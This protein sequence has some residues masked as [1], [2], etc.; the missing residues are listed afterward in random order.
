[1]I[2]IASVIT[3]S[4][5]SSARAF[6]LSL[7]KTQKKFQLFTL[8]V[9]GLRKEDSWINGFPELNALFPEDLQYPPYEEMTTYYDA[10]ELCN[11]MRPV[12][13]SYLLKVRKLP[14]II[15][16][17]TDILMV[18]TIP[19]PQ[20]LLL[21]GE[22][23][24]CP[25]VRWSYPADGLYPNNWHLPLYGPY[26]SGF[27]VFNHSPVSLEVLDFLS[28]QLKTHC[29]NSTPTCFVDQTWLPTVVS[30]YAREFVPLTDPGLNIAYWNLHERKLTKQNEVIYAESSPA[31]FFH[32]S[33]FDRANPTVVSKW[34]NRV[35]FDTHPLMN[36]VCGIYLAALE[37]FDGERVSGYRFDRI[38]GREHS[39]QQREDQY[40][41][42][43]S[44]VPKHLMPFTSP[45]P[46]STSHKS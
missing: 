10:F 24:F 46:S 43:Q 14:S 20:K 32:L 29:F 44:G 27:M 18:G 16:M 41:R 45:T 9:D 17:D 5:V 31:V 42:L 19:E 8:V 3:R 35:T 37:K 1:M 28:R 23:G 40:C 30:L 13:L 36:E 38:D 26:N 12:F 25:H 6:A 4:H 2:Y 39:A 7:S 11:A 34:T 33:G 15:Y 22:F 21:E